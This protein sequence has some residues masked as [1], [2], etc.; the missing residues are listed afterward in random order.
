MK[1]D[2]N[3]MGV[4]VN[5]HVGECES[6]PITNPITTPAGETILK[7]P[8]TL[9]ELTVRTNL[10]AKI[11]FSDP[12]LEIKDIKKRIKIVQCRLLLPGISEFDPAG[13]FQPRTLSLFI[14]GF[15]RKNIQYATPCPGSTDESVVSEIRSLT[16]DVPF[17]CVTKIN[18]EDFLTPP[19]L[20]FNNTRKEFDFFRAQELGHGYPEKD[21]LLSSDLSQFHQVS[22]QFYNEIPFCELL[23]SDIVEWD[24]AIDRKPLPGIAP[25]EEG[26]FHHVEEKMFLEFR[27]KVLQKQ[28]VRVIALPTPPGF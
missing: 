18:S 20:P 6:E 3:C 23:R 25:F 28:Q 13:P 26:I 7:V 15:V 24:E 17:K 10:V 5:A 22:T 2:E 21:Q 12:V 27:I 16:V 4:Q 1:K 8:V 9:A 14:K 19:Q 11:H